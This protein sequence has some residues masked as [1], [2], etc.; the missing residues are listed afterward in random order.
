MLDNHAGLAELDH[1]RRQREIGNENG[2]LAGAPSVHSRTI[3]ADTHRSVRDRPNTSSH[4]ILLI[5][6]GVTD[7]P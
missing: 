3:N 6:F 1:Q 2:E 7:E 5:F 4:L